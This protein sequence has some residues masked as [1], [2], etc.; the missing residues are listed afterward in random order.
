MKKSVF[1]FMA[2]VMVIAMTLSISVF[3]NEDADAV[4]FYDITAD[5][6]FYDAVNWGVGEGI[7]NGVGND[8]FDPYGSLTRA[9][10]VTLLWR[11]SGR[12]EAEVNDTFSDVVAGSWYEDA[13]KWAV[14]QG[15]TNG[16]GNNMFSPDMKLN[17]AMAITLLYR[18]KGSPFDEIAKLDPIELTDESSA[19]D[20]GVYL[21]Q[22]LID[23][24]RSPDLKSD[25]LLNSYYEMPVIWAA[26][27]N[28]LTEDNT[29]PMIDSFIFR[30][31]DIC[32]RAEMMSFLYQ[33]KLADDAAN[34]PETIELDNLIIPI[35]QEY[36]DRLYRMMY[37]I[38]TEDGGTVI[39]IA[40]LASVNAAEAMSEEVDEGVGELFRIEAIPESRLKEFMDGD[41]PNT[42]IFA[43]DESNGLYYAIIY[44]S[45]VRYVR[46]T[47]EQ[48]VA[49]Q[50]QWNELVEWA[51]SIVESIL[52]YS[53]NLTAID[54]LQLN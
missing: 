9:Q 34:A 17:R 44:P 5:D 26:I 27:S 2:M 12:P 30:P 39:V 7:T 48:M 47:T 19:E 40:E 18:L 54:N 1:R 51:S 10:A 4:V 46:E 16:T 53:E 35:P 31:D 29:N 24:F 42:I 6:Y 52:E 25:V 36:S 15:I 50:D 22:Q 20:F 14:E 21:I 13:V 43:K 37:G 49:D 11:M 8:L 41:I 32:T 3:A 33:S 45:D 28:I 23:I 38:D